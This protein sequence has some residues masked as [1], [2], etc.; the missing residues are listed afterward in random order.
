MKALVCRALAG[1]DGLAI[2][3]LPDPG[4][5]GPGQVRIRIAAAGL[6][7]ADLLVTAGKYQVKHAPPFVPGFEASGVVEAVG[8]EVADVQVGDRVMTIPEAGGLA[9]GAI[10]PAEAVYLAPKGL[11]EAEAAG[12]PIAYG[13]SYLALIEQAKLRAGETL[14]VHG[15]A[16]GVGLTAVEIGKALGARVIATAGGP[17]KCA[18]AQAHGADHVIDYKTEDIRERVKALVGGVDVVY[19]PVGGSAFEASLR[20]V[21]WN[22]RILIIGFAGGPVPQIPANILL[23]K[24]VAAMGFYFGSWRQRRPDLV[25]QAFLSLNGMVQAGQLKPLISHRLPLAD[26]RQALE[27]IR[28]RQSTGKVVLLTGATF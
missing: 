13:T 14:L 28:S 1:I 2:E 5:P 21:N 9:E 15:A 18:V 8:P 16:G 4:H 6:N 19:D 7:Y 25:A 26:F 22:A 12:F 20:V 3:E 10:V 23:V 17:G 24:N 27:L 11:D